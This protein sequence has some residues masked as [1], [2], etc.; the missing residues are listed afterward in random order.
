MKKVIFPIA[1]FLLFTGLAN[2]QKKDSTKSKHVTTMNKTATANKTTT[3]NT[4]TVSPGTTTKTTGSTGIKRKHP[5][6]KKP[7]A[8]KKG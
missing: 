3:S 1:A 5:R 2:A 4:S 8:T 6:K 7:A